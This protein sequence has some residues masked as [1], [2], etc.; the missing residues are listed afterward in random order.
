VILNLY[1]QLMNKLLISLYLFELKILSIINN[2]NIK[3]QINPFNLLQMLTVLRF[4]ALKFDVMIL[5]PR[6]INLNGI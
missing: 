3:N 5:F 2:S 1:E 6:Y 4:R